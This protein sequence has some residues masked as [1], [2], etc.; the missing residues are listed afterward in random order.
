MPPHVEAITQRI[1]DSSRLSR[2]RRGTIPMWDQDCFVYTF[3]SG[4]E[5][6]RLL[7]ADLHAAP[8]SS[9]V[10]QHQ[11]DATPLGIRCGACVLYWGAT[12]RPSTGKCARCSSR[13]T[14]GR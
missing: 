1:E 5:R 12:S 10:D 8:H 4:G 3:L 2:P 11:G 7:C 6:R 14:T 9:M 13:A